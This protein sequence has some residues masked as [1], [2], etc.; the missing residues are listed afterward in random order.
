M[1]VENNGCSGCIFVPGS[2]TI[3]HEYK[4]LSTQNTTNVDLLYLSFGRG[5]SSVLSPRLDR[6]DYFPSPLSGLTADS[7][8]GS[9]DLRTA[10]EESRG[11]SIVEA[12]STPGN[13]K[14]ERVF[15][16][17]PGEEGAASTS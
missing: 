8:R 16:Y 17:G 7:V 13:W 14:N 11:S 4:N 12:R 15:A 2:T 1:S 3:R 10:V 9:Q 6:F 5:R